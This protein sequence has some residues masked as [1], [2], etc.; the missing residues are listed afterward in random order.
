MQMFSSFECFG[1][2]I[3]EVP[4]GV[5]VGYVIENAGNI[6]ARKCAFDV[7]IILNTYLPI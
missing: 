1:S 2:S 6:C 3:T 4:K 5:I 7:K